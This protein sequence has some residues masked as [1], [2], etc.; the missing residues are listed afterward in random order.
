LP[1][2]DEHSGSLG[3]NPTLQP[4]SLKFFILSVGWSL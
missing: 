1:C 3:L 2:E 4:L